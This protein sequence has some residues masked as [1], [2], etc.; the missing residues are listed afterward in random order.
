VVILGNPG[1][2]KSTLVDWL[3]WQLADEHLNA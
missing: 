3:A 1:S 2:G